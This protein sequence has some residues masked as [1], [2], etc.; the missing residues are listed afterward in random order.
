MNAQHEKSCQFC[1]EFIPVPALLCRHCN[2]EQKDIKKLLKKRNELS[3]SIIFCFFL[4]LLV[5]VNFSL[6]LERNY[7]LFVFLTMLF[8]VIFT[9][10]QYLF[11]NQYIIFP[12]ISPSNLKNVVDILN[13]IKELKKFVRIEIAIC[14]ILIFISLPTKLYL[15]T[16]IPSYSDFET[17]LD[18]NTSYTSSQILSEYK[19]TFFNLYIL[20]NNGK[21]VSYMGIADNFILVSN[22]VKKD[23][24]ELTEKKLIDFLRKSK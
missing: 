17:Y 6:L 2:N 21:Y 3:F 16:H 14:L 22:D 19:D 11:I 7:V 20:E 18:K 23:A 1:A 5:E 10:L 4:T 9:V 15:N 13:E 8:I 24:Y 12:R